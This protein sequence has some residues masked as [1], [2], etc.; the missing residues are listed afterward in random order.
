MITL[1]ILSSSAVQ[2]SIAKRFAANLSEK[3]HTEINISKVSINY[4]LH[5][6]LEDV[7]INDQRHNVLLN[8]NVIDCKVG[9]L[10]LNNKSIS[11]SKIIFKNTQVDLIKY[12]SDTVMNFQFLV[13]YFK[14]EDTVKSK[15][16]WKIS[17]KSIE[18]QNTKFKY[19][20]QDEKDY[21]ANGFDYNNIEL[22]NLNVKID[23]LL[24]KGDT[25]FVKIDKLGFKDKSGYVVKN[26]S[27]KIKYYPGLISLQNLNLETAFSNLN[28]D[29]KLSYDNP[30][31]LKDFL[32]KVNIQADIRKS[33]VSLKDIAYFNKN[34]KGDDNRI[35]F[36]GLISGKVN[37]IKLRDFKFNYGHTTD[38]EGN[39]S[40]NGLPD[41]EQTFIRLSI[42]KFTTS[43]ADIES[44][45]I[46]GVINN[47]IQVPTSLMA[48][49]AIIIKG[50]F[51]G[52]YNDFNANAN[53]Y[54]S[55]GQISTDIALRKNKQ[56]KI[57]YKGH[58][59]A[60]K[61][62]IGEYL[63]LKNLM[64]K[65]N[66]DAEISGSGLKREDAK[67]EMTGGINAFEFKGN[68][69]D[70][71]AIKGQFTNKL[72]DG[73]LSVVDNKVDFN[74]LGNIDFSSDLPV[75]DFTATIKDANLYK[76]KLV[77]SDSTGILSTRLNFNFNGNTAD[78]IKGLI[79][80]EN[81]SYRKGKDEYNMKLLSINTFNDTAG[82][83]KI[84]LKSDFITADM[85]GS[86]RFTDLPAALDNFIEKYLPSFTPIKIKNKTEVSKNDQKFVFNILLRNTDELS[87][88]F[89]PSLLIAKNA[90]ING[91]YNSKLSDLRLN[92]N[93][94]ELTFNGKQFKDWYFDGVTDNKRLYLTTGCSR[95]AIS[96]SL[97]LD[98]LKLK[99]YLQSDSILFFV[100]WE[101]KNS[102]Y[103]HNSGDISGYASFA[104]VPEI[105]IALTK[106][107]IIVNDSVWRLRGKN[108]I[109]IDSSVISIDNLTVSSGF[110]SIG[111]EGKITKNPGEKIYLN[112]SKFDIANFAFFLEPKNIYLSGL[113]S[114]NVGFYDLYKSPNFITN[115]NIQDLKLNKDLF[116]NANLVTTWDKNRDA[117]YSKLVIRYK[118]N[119]GEADRIVADGY[120]YPNDP[121]QNFDFKLSLFN[122]RI[123][124]IGH[125]L[126]SFSS[127]FEGQVSGSLT[128]KGTVDKPIVKG[129]VKLDRTTMKID[130]LNTVY[131][132]S[133]SVEIGINYFAFNNFV[134]TDENHN[135]A[136]LDGKI[137]HDAF[138]NIRLD[139]K[140]TTK[141]FMMLNTK[142]SDNDMYYGKAFASGVIKIT[143]P[144]NDI[145]LDIIAKTEKG[146][147][148][149]IPISDK[150]VN[151]DNSYITF[152]DKNVEDNKFRYRNKAIYG[153]TMKF[154]LEITPEAQIGLNVE[155]GNT[156]GEIR[157]NGNGNIQMVIDDAGS[158]NM[159][160]NYTIVEGLYFFSIQNLTSKK[161]T[162]A[163]GATIDFNGDPYNANVK[164]KAVY[165][166][167]ASL[168]PVMLAIGSTD[169]KKVAVQS[170]ISIDGKLANPNIDFDINLPNTD[171]EIRDQF[172]TLVDKNDKN[173]MNQQTFSLLVVNSFISKDRTT[174][175]A[176]VGSSV[177][178]S[179]AEMI[180]N[181][182]SNWLSQINKDFDININYRPTDQLTNQE[183]QVMLST[184]ILNDRI[185]LNGNAVVGGSIKDQANGS[186]QSP[187]QNA[188]NFIGDVNAEVKLTEDGRFKLKVFNR[189]NQ[190]DLLN[191]YSPYTQG[192]G[193]MYRREFDNIR[194]V[195][196]NPVK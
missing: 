151:R 8:A 141:K 5:I 176:S 11:F 102:I 164:M 130:Y 68:V 67:I 54:S 125:Y 41:I 175:S 149:V 127:E 143:G 146:T 77:N 98:N 109:K 29:I 172:F 195:F 25:V 135:T 45:Y 81:T 13:D 171:Q 53:L 147:E 168:Y 75:F 110:Q 64:G 1:A 72:F 12:H 145:K 74:F 50:D 60:K 103:H 144:D 139:L 30:E 105:N 37:N 92:G 107:D 187:N 17:S 140:V 129:K 192:I 161:F 35:A 173:Q 39:I 18:F 89:F 115:I 128:L 166:L 132:L 148:L 186:S 46:P 33:N 106:S 160:G 99:S 31:A 9:H 84:E 100:N 188:N 131:S 152:I 22:T 153:V 196:K 137:T 112:L 117:L 138:R 83:R 44:L 189:S 167:K 62:N 114:G 158:F 49:G 87:R 156:G 6:L 56:N 55:I 40:M 150:T 157:A 21:K 26:F 88:L 79:K 24:L 71:I 96:D 154:N 155:T 170:I 182:I 136:R 191:N 185:S 10:S 57:E 2:T 34:F 85:Y 4:K 19:L 36:S 93:A 91:S 163:S 101:D 184:Q 181:Q 28:L 52:F 63:D 82:Q 58:I 177:G 3:L 7:F 94:T 159:Y 97:G 47:H 121:N 190:Y 116:G 32:N 120:Y 194:E 162:I 119:V 123:A 66:L 108:N 42:T 133:D 90:T 59:N 122:Q 86:F 78:N 61:F 20:N 193:I 15:T 27:S 124:S 95:L 183:L 73:Y 174:Y 65:L 51:T 14:S 118:G 76:L 111:I 169:K 134:F 179:S 16:S 70:S 142:S 38:F 165:N 126:K 23:S 178:N 113:V 69:Y 180:S 43:K 104:N 48:L 80:V